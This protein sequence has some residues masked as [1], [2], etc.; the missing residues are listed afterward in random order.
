MVGDVLIVN[1]ANSSN[2]AMVKVLTVGGGGSLASVQLIQTGTDYV[3][4]S[5]V[6]LLENT[7]GGV[8]TGGTV[9]ITASSTP[10]T[11]DI[12]VNF[13]EVTQG[14]AGNVTVTLV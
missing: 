12:G 5:G 2:A 13:N 9:N 4:A 11:L 14:I 1:Q 8:G 6:A 3:T 10:L 7:V